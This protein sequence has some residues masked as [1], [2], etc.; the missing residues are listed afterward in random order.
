MTIHSSITVIIER[1]HG[2]ST[3]RHVV[4]AHTTLLLRLLL[5][6]GGDRWLVGARW[7][8]PIGW[9]EAPTL[10]HGC[11]ETSALLDDI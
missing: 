5:L 2:R 10:V 6:P 3:G 7:S 8:G 1:G 9:S 11:G 4:G